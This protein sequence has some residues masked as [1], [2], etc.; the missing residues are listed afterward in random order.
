MPETKHQ[1]VPASSNVMNPEAVDNRYA[2]ARRNPILVRFITFDYQPKSLN[3]GT[4]DRRFKCT[5]RFQSYKHDQAARRVSHAW[6]LRERAGCGHQSSFSLSFL[7]GRAVISPDSEALG[8]GTIGGRFEL[9][10]YGG[11]GLDGGKARRSGRVRILSQ[12][13]M[14][15]T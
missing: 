7:G 10:T 6:N 12:S 8:F 9:V 15:E 1:Q 14:I 5:C 2:Q 4:I 13:V 3:R 11:R